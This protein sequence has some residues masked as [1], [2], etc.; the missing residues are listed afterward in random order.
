MPLTRR[1]ARTR[2]GISP[3]WGCISQVP[4]NVV[5]ERVS[6][7]YVEY[8]VQS[9]R[10]EPRTS[11]GMPSRPDQ[12]FAHLTTCQIP[13]GQCFACLTTRS[14]VQAGASYTSKEMGN[15]SRS[16][17]RTPNDMSNSPQGLTRTTMTAFKNCCR[18]YCRSHYRVAPP[19]PPSSPPPPASPI[20]D[21][22]P[23]A[24]GIRSPQ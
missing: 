15:P 10:P 7:L 20:I 24:L 21:N 1:C 3:I 16:A 4:S 23:G 8:R 9:P 14:A 22:R 18:I 11:N 13:P 12:S 19:P 17:P 6:A 2:T 5:W